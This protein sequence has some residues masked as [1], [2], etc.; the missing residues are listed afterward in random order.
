M[1][2]LIMD[3]H[4]IPIYVLAIII[5]LLDATLWRPWW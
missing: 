1:D 4:L 2:G 3:R 5:I